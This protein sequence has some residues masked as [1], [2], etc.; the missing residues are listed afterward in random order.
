MID[1]QSDYYEFESNVWLT[2]EQRK[3][4]AAK[5]KAL[6]AALHTRGYHAQ[7]SF[8]WWHPHGNTLKRGRRGGRGQ[9]TGRIH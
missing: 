1:D 9:P 7:P 5:A 2:E 8:L 4:K 6:E 3:E